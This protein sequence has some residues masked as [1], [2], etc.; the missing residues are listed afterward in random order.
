MKLVP[1][2]LTYNRRM[3]IAQGLKVIINNAKNH[4]A[5]PKS[6]KNKHRHKSQLLNKSNIIADKDL[7]KIS[8]DN[9]FLSLVG[10]NDD[11]NNFK[12][13]AIKELKMEVEFE[14]QKDGISI[15]MESSLAT[16]D[17]TS[18]VASD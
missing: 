9:P 14:L 11:V 13:D 17:F 4:A 5:D 1:R 16:S 6:F 15:E 10:V 18:S 3:D 2:A 7:D 12:F 8:P